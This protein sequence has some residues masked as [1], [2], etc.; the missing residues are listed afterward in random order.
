M[1]DLITTVDWSRWQ[2]ALTAIYHWL[3]VPLTLGLA[4]IVGIME[5]IYVKTGDD[6]WLKTTKFWMTLFGINFAIGVAT[7][8]ILEFEFGTN[9]SNY[10]WFVGDIF[11]APLAIEGLLAF[12]MEATF[13]AVMFFGWGKVSK[14]FHLASTWLTALGAS[15]SALWILVAN[16]WMQ[17][18]VG[19][20]F[21][22]AQMRNVMDNF[23]ALFSGIAV[24]KFFHAVLSGWALAGVFVIAV[25]CWFLLK[26]KNTDFAIRSIKVGAWTGLVGLLLTMYT[27]D[28]SAVQVTRHQPMKLA[29]MEGLY[30]GSTSQS[31]VAVGL[32]NPDKKW[33]NDEDPYLFN[34]DLPYGLSILA[35]HD[36]NAFVPG[37]NDI[38]AGVDINE[39]GDTINTV[40]YAERI[41]RGKAAQ[42][43]LRRFDT[44]R[45]AG[46]AAAMEKAR[47]D[48][49]KD[50]KFFGYGYFD[51]VDQAIPPV[52]L[53]FYS[54][55][56]MVIVGSYL[57]L[58]FLVVLF[59]AYRKQ[60]LQREKWLQW[61][62]MMT[63]LLVY[64][65]SQAGW[66]VAEVGRQPWTVQDLLPTCA[67]ISDIPSA[68]VITTFW[69]FA[70]IFTMLLIAEVS[71]MCRYI[72]QNAKKQ[73][74]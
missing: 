4:V 29:A 3:F 57:I 67:A 11:G 71:I 41:E 22:P 27:G 52:A 20:E 65:C 56:V 15:I 51:S 63:L 6:K 26:K 49:M 30:N 40:S 13:V 39:Q 24:N 12:F 2:F 23:W 33:N 37:I 21:D 5:S 36:A 45:K 47:A 66:I 46:D 19:M 14:G 55:R 73:L 1:N 53:T 68:S 28:G 17:Y 34:V 62:A 60:W 42:E 59:A 7:G 44:A 69:I 58:F 43:S 35:R 9:W 72:S 74:D 16:A 31:L 25:S 70:A 38:I 50:Y 61:T 8:L 10:S 18:P 54:F 32:V 64:L 48:M